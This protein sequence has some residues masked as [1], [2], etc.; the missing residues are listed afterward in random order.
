MKRCSLLLAIRKMQIKTMR[1]HFISTR[2]VVIKK[3]DNNKYRNSVEKA[4]MSYI[5]AGM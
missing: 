4:E 3:R 5:A 1:D 2:V